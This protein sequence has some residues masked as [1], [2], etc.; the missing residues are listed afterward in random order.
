MARAMM[1]VFT[2]G[3][4]LYLY[5]YRP[6]SGIKANRLSRNVDKAEFMVRGSTQKSHK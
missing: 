3:I 5:Y 6:I 2:K 1:T 4:K